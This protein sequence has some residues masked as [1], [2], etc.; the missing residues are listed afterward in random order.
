MPYTRTIEHK[1]FEFGHQPD[2]VVTFEY[3]DVWRDGMEPYYPVNDERNN[4]L[5]GKYKS[6]ADNE[7]SVLFGGR[8][9]E[10]KYYDMDKVVERVLSCAW[11]KDE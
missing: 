5:F 10:F 3:P 4:V 1:H 11:L 2:T 6:L 7:E 8:L 9:G